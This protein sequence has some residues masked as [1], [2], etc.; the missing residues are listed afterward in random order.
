MAIK[1]MFARKAWVIRDVGNIEIAVE[2]VS[3]FETWDI[4]TLELLR[5]PDTVRVL[6][7]LIL[8]LR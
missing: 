5:T 6:A 2:G 7:L 1:G 4:T 8:G 3:G